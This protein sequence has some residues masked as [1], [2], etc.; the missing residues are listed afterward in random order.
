MAAGTG[1]AIARELKSSIYPF[2]IAGHIYMVYAAVPAL[3]LNLILSIA[4]SWIME[5]LGHQRGA[6][7]TIATDYA[8]QQA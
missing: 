4:L 5:A 2:H 3:A 1:M 6:D 8:E 7:A